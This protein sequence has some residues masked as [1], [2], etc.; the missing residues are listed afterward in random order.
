MTTKA[1]VASV[2]VGETVTL[3]VS[4]MATGTVKVVGAT[5]KALRIKNE[6]G[7]A[8]AWIPRSALTIDEQY[9]VVTDSF[10]GLGLRIAPWFVRKLVSGPDAYA[11]VAAGLSCW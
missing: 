4:G 6:Q 3:V 2:T 1:T 11:R 9:T 10:R 8:T 5:P 7:R